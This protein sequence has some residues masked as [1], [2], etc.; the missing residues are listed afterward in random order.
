M[1]GIESLWAAGVPVDQVDM[2]RMGLAAGSADELVEEILLNHGT[3]A[4][5]VG[6]V[7]LN[8]QLQAG[9]PPLV[10]QP[11]GGVFALNPCHISAAVGGALN[12]IANTANLANVHAVMR[13]SGTPGA[14]DTALVAGGL[15]GTVRDSVSVQTPASIAN[16]DPTNPRIDVVYVTITRD[17]AAFN[18]SRRYKDPGSGTVSTVNQPM[19]SDVKITLAVQPG[20]P[21][22]SPTVPSIPASTSTSWTH[23]LVQV[24]VPALYVAGSVIAASAIAPVWNRLWISPGRI[25]KTTPMSSMAGAP[26]PRMDSQW[27]NGVD[28]S[29]VFK[30]TSSSQTINLDTNVLDWRKRM[31]KISLMQVNAVVGVSMPLETTTGVGCAVSAESGP[32]WIPFATAGAEAIWTFTHTSPNIT[33]EFDVSTTGNL[34]VTIATAPLNSAGDVYFVEF[35]ATD[36]FTA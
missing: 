6:V 8:P 9:Y 34:S 12:L 24:T 23:A 20:T 21:A 14:D 7:P 29:A 22:S 25:R 35:A 1:S 32:Q 10:T 19:A 16:G 28:R 26:S 11:S 3:S 2:D 17:T 18:V 36:Q 27:G 33:M 15:S 13:P 5:S 30:H 31:V 4:V